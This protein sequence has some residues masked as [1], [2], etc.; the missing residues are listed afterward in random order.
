M[1]TMAAA[2]G[3]SVHIFTR[4]LQAGFLS[5]IGALVFFGLLITSHDDEGKNL[6]RRVL[7][8]LGFAGL[9]E[10]FRTNILI[11]QS[12]VSMSKRLSNFCEILA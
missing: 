9:S 6:Q 11:R 4:I 12:A 8:L 5:G 10:Y 1:A 2:V 3:A 7:Y